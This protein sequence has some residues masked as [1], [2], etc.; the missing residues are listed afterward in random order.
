MRYFSPEPTI[1]LTAK[2]P[3]GKIAYLEGHTGLHVQF[4]GKRTLKPLSETISTLPAKTRRPLALIGNQHDD[5]AHALRERIKELECLYTISRLCEAHLHE[6]DMFLQGVVDCLPR[7]WQYPE[8]CAARITYGKMVHITENFHEG[9]WQMSA[10]VDD[11][12]KA[13]G[14]VT[15]FYSKGVP[16]S[17]GGPF[18]PEEHSLLR[19]IA[20]RVATSLAHMRTESELVDAHRSLR[21][22]HQLL[23]ER[24]ITLRTVL[25][26]LE[27]EK[28]EIRAAILAN[29]QKVIMPIVFELEL[30]VTGRQRSYVTLLRQSLQEIASPFLTS[31]S[32]DHVELTPVEVAISAMIRNGMSTKDIANLRCI[33]PATVRRHRENVRKKLG[34]TNRQVNLVTYLQSSSGHDSSAPGNKSKSDREF[35]ISPDFGLGNDRQL[36]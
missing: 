7:T 15:V 28:R 22:Q 4:M 5:I 27:E 21:A 32:R 36:H 6:A 12:G 11:H 1:C 33:T 10:P 8:F 35:S 13:V 24:N 25:S 20:E 26:G 17:P 19:V 2:A 30:A 31:L 3:S 29:I 18:L 9:P 14:A 34:L 23:Q 16:V